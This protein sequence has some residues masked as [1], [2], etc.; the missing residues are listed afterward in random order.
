MTRD[1]LRSKLLDVLTDKLDEELTLRDLSRLINDIIDLADEH[2]RPRNVSGLVGA[3]P[4]TT[5]P[6]IPPNPYTVTNIN[7]VGT[8]QETM[9]NMVKDGVISVKEAIGHLDPNPPM[10]HATDSPMY[11]I[12]PDALMRKWRE[13]KGEK[14]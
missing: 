12:G 13:S 6:Y 5:L 2:A 11:A 8:R 7:C 10:S 14:L 1:E 3:P 9:E 4:V